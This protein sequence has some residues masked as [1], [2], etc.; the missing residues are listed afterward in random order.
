MQIR[1]V[2]ICKVLR[3]RLMPNERQVLVF[4]PAGDSGWV[5]WI[6]FRTEISSGRRALT[7]A[8]TLDANPPNRLLATLSLRWTCDTI[9]NLDEQ[10]LTKGKHLSGWASA[11]NSRCP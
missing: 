10:R 8:P 6:L 4:H 9:L 11:D 5:F 3:K 1:Q 7:L 2:N